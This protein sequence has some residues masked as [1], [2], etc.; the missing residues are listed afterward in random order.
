MG[1]MGKNDTES[2]FLKTGGQKLIEYRWY[3]SFCVLKN[4]CD[5]RGIYYIMRKHHYDFIEARFVLKGIG[6]SLIN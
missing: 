3:V 2:F 4:A 6:R 5:E 1:C